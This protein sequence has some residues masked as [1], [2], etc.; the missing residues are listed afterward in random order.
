MCQRCTDRVQIVVKHLGQRDGSQAD[1][2]GNVHGPL[3]T[4]NVCTV[5]QPMRRLVTYGQ[6]HIKF[7]SLLRGPAAPVSADGSLPV[8]VDVGTFARGNTHSV[9]SACFLPSG[10]VLTGKF[11]VPLIWLQH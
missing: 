10:I 4:Q 11:T 9:L 3:Q 2:A 6:N 5:P 7:W 8:N 1:S